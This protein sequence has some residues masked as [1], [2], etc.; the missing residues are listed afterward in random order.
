MNQISIKSEIPNDSLKI[1]FQILSSYLP[2]Y[3]K[4]IYQH[5]IILK[6]A[7]SM[8]IQPN[9]RS[10]ENYYWEKIDTTLHES[11]PSF[12]Y[13][14]LVNNCFL[15]CFP[16]ILFINVYLSYLHLTFIYV[17]LKSLTLLL[18]YG[19]HHTEYFFLFFIL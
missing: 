6:I 5:Y 16:H 18:I 15:H 8:N 13:I 12:E 1:I 7:S 10:Q 14:L 9:N 19:L 3:K 2:R 11:Q 17:H 4:L